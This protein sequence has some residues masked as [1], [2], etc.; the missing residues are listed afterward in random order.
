MTER[1]ILNTRN[2]GLKNIVFLTNLYSCTFDLI[3][4]FEISISQ[5]IIIIHGSAGSF[6]KAYKCILHPMIRRARL[7]INGSD[8]SYAAG[9]SSRSASSM[10]HLISSWSAGSAIFI[11]LTHRCI[12]PWSQL[13][14]ETLPS[15]KI[16][17]SLCPFFGSLLYVFFVVSISPR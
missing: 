12:G 1:C 3:C 2:I 11:L 10:F 16:L 14:K 8:C 15:P 13:A 9:Y 17:R 6:V 4:V 7:W 5:P